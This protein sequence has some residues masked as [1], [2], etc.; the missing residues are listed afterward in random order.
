MATKEAAKAIL[1]SALAAGK[2][3]A[4]AAGQGAKEGIKGAVKNTVRNEAKRV[5][6]SRFLVPGTSSYAEVPAFQ[7]PSVAP[8]GMMGA[9][10]IQSFPAYC[11]CDEN[12]RAQ[13]AYNGKRMMMCH[14]CGPR[15]MGVGDFKTQ[16]EA[17]AAPLVGRARPP[18]NYFAHLVAPHNSLIGSI[19]R[20]SRKVSRS[21]SR[22]KSN[23]KKST[24][25]AK[26]S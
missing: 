1:R 26:S 11:A 14:R 15:G 19:L 18:A 24:R 16:Y 25:K 9:P 7:M 21:K 5:L 10:T 12:P 3:A 6:R 20:G 4:K 2:G 22:S 13:K 17:G 8:M 23:S